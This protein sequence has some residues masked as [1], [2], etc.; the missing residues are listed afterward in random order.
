M[1]QRNRE[2]LTPAQ[3]MWNQRHAAYLSAFNF[4]AAD[5]Q[6]N[7]TGALSPKQRADKMTM[8]VLQ[9]LF[10]VPLYSFLALA[11]VRNGFRV[12]IDDWIAGLFGLAGSSGAFAVAWI[13]LAVAALTI[14]AFW[15]LP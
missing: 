1:T 14:S 15:W 6:V 9:L 8:L 2:K 4:A 10:G 3:R 12:G 5:L 13:A 11:I 7:N